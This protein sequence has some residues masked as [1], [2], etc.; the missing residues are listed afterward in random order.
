MEVEAVLFAVR[1]RHADLAAQAVAKFLLGGR[2]ADVA[3]SDRAGWGL[4]FVHPSEQLEV[5]SLL[6]SF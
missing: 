3:V 5:L 2:K 1:L 4:L 6:Q